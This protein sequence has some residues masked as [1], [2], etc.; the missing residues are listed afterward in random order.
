MKWK[1]SDQGILKN[2]DLAPSPTPTTLLSPKI[3]W[4]FFLRKNWCLL[5]NYPQKRWLWCTVYF[6]ERYAGLFALSLSLPFLEF[7]ISTT[8]RNSRICNLVRIKTSIYLPYPFC[9]LL[10]RPV[11]YMQRSDSLCT[12]WIENMKIGYIFITLHNLVENVQKIDPD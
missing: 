10:F 3:W 1:L 9:V 4:F 2:V 8:Y 12:I 6:H 11:R 7:K 5:T